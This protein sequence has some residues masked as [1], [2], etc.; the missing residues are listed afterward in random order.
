MSSRGPSRAAAGAAAADPPA[1]MTTFTARVLP[2]AIAPVAN[3]ADALGR[4]EQISTA[5]GMPPTAA[6]FVGNKFVEMLT[7]HMSKVGLAKTSAIPSHLQPPQAVQV[8]R[9]DQA[10]YGQCLFWVDPN[11][12]K[13]SASGAAPRPEVY[14]TSTKR[15]HDCMLQ[16]G[17]VCL[18]THFLPDDVSLVPPRLPDDDDDGDAVGDDEDDE[19]PLFGPPA[20]PTVACSLPKIAATESENLAQVAVREFEDIAVSRKIAY[21]PL[22][23]WSDELRQST[24]KEMAVN[25][26]KSLQEIFYSR[27]KTYVY[28]RGYSGQEP[29]NIG[30]RF[31]DM[32]MNAD[33]ATEDMRKEYKARKGKKA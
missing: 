31:S 10:Q 3:L 15:M 11:A 14:V 33:R 7:A 23:Q 26:R 25:E 29:K 27:C 28:I 12:L 18:P 2:L 5:A 24:W 30:L 8:V 16:K 1:T 20:V 13:R 4:L 21:S 19:P 9:A 17:Y 22:R 32:V 6:S